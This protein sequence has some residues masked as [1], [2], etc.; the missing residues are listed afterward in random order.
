MRECYRI[1]DCNWDGHWERMEESAQSC[2]CRTFK[3]SGSFLKEQPRKTWNEVIRSELKE[4]KVSSTAKEMLGVFHMKPTNLCKHGKQILKQIWWQSL[5]TN[6][7]LSSDKLSYTVSGMN[8][9]VEF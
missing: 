7:L 6:D 9:N 3:V 5:G 1:E 4:R 2:K 8:Y